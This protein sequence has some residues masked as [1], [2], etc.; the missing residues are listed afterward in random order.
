MKENLK[1]FSIIF[2]AALFAVGCYVSF[3]PFDIQPETQ[4][5]TD[6]IVINSSGNDT[7]AAVGNFIINVDLD[8]EFGQMIIMPEYRRV[9]NQVFRL[10]FKCHGINIKGGV[11]SDKEIYRINNY[12]AKKVEFRKRSCKV[13]V[14]TEELE[15]TF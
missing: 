8:G 1:T 2:I 11:V 4:Q 9:D 5:S 7:I 10:P 6:T 13:H 15:L 12:G 3:S 14:F